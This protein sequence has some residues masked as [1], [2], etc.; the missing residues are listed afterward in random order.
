[1]H[2]NY[3]VVVEI[4]CLECYRK[5]APSENKPYGNMT[6]V[7]MSFMKVQDRELYISHDFSEEAALY[8]YCKR[9]VM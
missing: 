9:G 2:Y 3:T 4:V 7:D 5:V 8:G 6:S 1:M